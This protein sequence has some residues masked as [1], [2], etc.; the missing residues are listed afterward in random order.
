MKPRVS[1]L[2]LIEKKKKKTY[3]YTF[4][5]NALFIIRFLFN[6]KTLNFGK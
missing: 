5:D 3:P 6:I 4:A 2:E 1:K